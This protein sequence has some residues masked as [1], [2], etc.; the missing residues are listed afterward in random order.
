MLHRIF[1]V[2]RVSV[3]PSRAGPSRW[4][5]LGGA[6]LALSVATIGQQAKAQGAQLVAAVPSRTDSGKARADSVAST[7]KAAAALPKWF[8]DLAVNAFVSTAY[9]YNGNRPTTGASS[10]RVFDF[11]DN[12]FNLDVAELVVQI[13]ASKPNDAGFRV[14]FDA[15]NSIPQITKTQDQTAAQFDLKQAFASYIAPLG[16]G[17]RFDVGKFVTHMGYEVIEGYDGYNDN[18]SRSILFG[19]AIPFTHTGVKASYAF[20]SK[21]AGMVEVVNGWDLLRDNNRSKSVGAQLTLTPVAPLQVLLNWIGGPELANDNHTNRNVFDLVAILKPTNTLTLGVNGDYGKEN[22]TSLV[23]PGSDAT[24]K[25]IAGYATLALT[26]KFSVALRGETFHDEDGVRLGTGTRATLSD[27]TFTPTYK[28]TDHVLLRGE[29]RYDK[30]NQPILTKR[31]TLAD[32]QTT[33]AAN[34]IFVY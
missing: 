4:T 34:V 9:E 1:G 32:T 7:T 27:G 8:D 28:F 2:A 14:D 5:R 25:G 10:Y 20:S 22:G 3:P 11:N 29:A 33:V 16:S 15:G 31:G 19:Y 17:L 6:L 30:A 21:V 26:N 23:N 12:S 24:W 18:Y 13:A